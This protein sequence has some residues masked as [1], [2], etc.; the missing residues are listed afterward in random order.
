MK[1]LPFYVNV[2]FTYNAAYF[3]LTIQKQQQA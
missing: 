1:E 3:V 2:L